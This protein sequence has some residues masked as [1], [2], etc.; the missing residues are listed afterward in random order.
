MQFKPIAWKRALT[1]D[2]LRLIVSHFSLSSE[3]DDLLFLSMFYTAFFG[4][5]RLG[6]LTFPNDL[7]ICDWHKV[8]HRSSVTVTLLCY[9][10]LL[11]AHKRNR[12]FEGNRV[13]I[14]S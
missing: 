9:E 12:F 13:L 1:C 5:M 7:S 14:C 2:D 6:E 11:P 8:T 10:F 4:L 3:H